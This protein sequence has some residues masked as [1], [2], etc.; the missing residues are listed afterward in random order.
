MNMTAEDFNKT[1]GAYWQTVSPDGTSPLTDQELRMWVVEL[2]FENAGSV[3]LADAEALVK[4]IKT[5]EV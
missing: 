1:F 3:A 5:G 4:Y 2:M